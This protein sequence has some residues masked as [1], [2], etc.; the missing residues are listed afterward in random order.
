M[1]ILIYIPRTCCSNTRDMLFE[2]PEH[3]TRTRGT[4]Y[5]NTHCVAEAA[6]ARRRR[7]QW[8]TQMCATA[9]MLLCVCVCVCVCVFDNMFRGLEHSNTPI[10]YIYIYSKPITT[11]VFKHSVT[12]SF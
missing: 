5:S 4:C 6:A 9:Q 11:Y 2:H 12:F 8:T 3:V 7:Q 10:I 1:Y